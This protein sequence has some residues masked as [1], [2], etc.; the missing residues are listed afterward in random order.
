LRHEE[1][2]T[3]RHQTDQPVFR[4]HLE[5]KNHSLSAGPASCERQAFSPAHPA[6]APDAPDPDPSRKTLVKFA[7]QK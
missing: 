5:R 2:E 6:P 4:T 3:L 1:Q 7:H